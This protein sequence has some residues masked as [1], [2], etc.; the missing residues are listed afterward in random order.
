MKIDNWDFLFT[1]LMQVVS[2]NVK[3]QQVWFSQTC[4]NLM[5]PT[6]LQ[7]LFDNLQ[8]LFDNLQQAGK[9]HNL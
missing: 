6:D 4:C 8:Q 2:G 5:K 9:I 1:S 3:L 7:Q